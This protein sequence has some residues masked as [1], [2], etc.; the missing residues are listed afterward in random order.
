MSNDTVP[1]NA[2]GM[3]IAR[4]NFIRGAVLALALPAPAVSAAAPDE[5]NRMIEKCR[6]LAK[7]GNELEELCFQIFHRGD[8]PE[9]PYILAKEFPMHC[10]PMK[11]SSYEA[12]SEIDKRM[13]RRIEERRQFYA[14]FA[15]SQSEGMLDWQIE[16]LEQNVAEAELDRARLHQLFDE[17]EARYDAW[18]ISSGHRAATDASSEV[19]G[20]FFD[21]QDEILAFQCTTAAELATKAAYIVAEWGD[22]F[23]Q[24]QQHRF[25]LEVA[26][27]GKRGE[28]A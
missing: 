8:R 2:E 24:G 22:E 18:D 5:L 28:A 26:A 10:W 23:A 7:E 17:R 21:L 15:E 13:D 19:W 11:H 3:P 1:A 27:F 6:R 16:R 25:I 14:W 12:R 9:R 4:R 20:R